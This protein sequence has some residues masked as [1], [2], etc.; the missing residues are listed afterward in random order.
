MQPISF[1]FDACTSLTDQ[2]YWMEGFFFLTPFLIRQKHW[3]ALKYDFQESI[4]INCNWNSKYLFHQFSWSL[5]ISTGLMMSLAQDW[6]WMCKFGDGGDDDGVVGGNGC[7]WHKLISAHSNPYNEHIKFPL[8]IIYT[9]ETFIFM[10][11]RFLS[12]VL[13][14]QPLKPR[15]PLEL[16]TRLVRLNFCHAQTHSLALEVQLQWFFYIW[17]ATSRSNKP[18]DILFL[19]FFSLEIKRS[20]WKIWKTAYA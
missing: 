17:L 8:K 12:T 14:I 1:A 15:Q 16:A 6:W 5:F 19:V 10:V 9:L 18:I 2:Q 13:N 20:S 7:N 3:N 4:I 11:G